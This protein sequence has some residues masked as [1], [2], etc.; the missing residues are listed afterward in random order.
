MT[1]RFRL[2]FVGDVVGPDGCAAVRALA[3]GLREEL[4]LDAVIA[5]GENSAPNGMGITPESGETLL[6]AV[7]FLTLGDHAFDH[8]EA[9]EYLDRERRAV[10]PANLEGAAKGRG[11]GVL[12][13]GGTRVGTAS[14]QGTVFM[15]EAGSPFRAADLVVRGL[16]AAG[17]DLILLDVHA[18]A[19]SEKQA[20]G[21]YLAG[22]VAAVVGTH[23]RPDRRCA[24]A[25]GRHRLRSRRRDDGRSRGRH[26][27]Q[28]GKVHARL[29]G[30]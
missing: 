15:R 24:R 10:R 23:A 12:E 1:S 3:P 28:P 7:D 16:K 25:A 18:E 6:A 8:E 19:T 30:W 26:R 14:V 11:W 21:W 9:G 13:A 20:L 5:N 2:L 4:G 27:A 17:A 22:R 29:F